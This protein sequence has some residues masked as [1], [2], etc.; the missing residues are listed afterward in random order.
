MNG[1]PA[2]LLSAF[3]NGSPLPSVS[4]LSSWSDN[5]WRFPKCIPSVPAPVLSWS[6]SMSDGTVFSDEKWSSLLYQFRAV[7]WCLLNRHPHL[8][9]LKP[10]NVSIFSVAIRPLARWMG[11]RSITSLSELEPDFCQRYLE[12]RI[13]A[14]RTQASELK[15]TSLYREAHFLEWI[16][17]VR[18]TLQDFG[19]APM[20]SPPFRHQRAAKVVGQIV[21]PPQRKLEPVPESITI[22]LL[23]RSSALLEVPADDAVK[24]ASLLASAHSEISALRIS[25]A[26]KFRKYCERISGF[27]FSPLQK[28]DKPWRAPVPPGKDAVD[29]AYRLIFLVR[30]AALVFFQASTG[31]RSSEFGALTCDSSAVGTL[32]NC[33]SVVRSRS[34]LNELFVL[35][36]TTVKLERHERK[37]EWVIGLRPIGSSYIPPP[38]RALIVLKDLLKPWRDAAGTDMLIV[39]PQWTIGFHFSTISNTTSALHLA[40]RLRRFAA[41]SL[42]PADPQHSTRDPDSRI[43]I[44]RGFK[45]LRPHRWRTTWALFAYRVDARLLT[46]I[47]IHFKHISL[48][49]T[50]RGYIGNDLEQLQILDDV[51]RDWT[52]RYFYECATG[53]RIPHGPLADLVKDHRLW[54]ARRKRRASARSLLTAI[55]RGVDEH[56]LRIWSLEEGKCLVSLWPKESRCHELAQS[57]HWSRS[58]PNYSSR[59]AGV[60]AS[61]K[62]FFPDAENKRFWIER[63]EQNKRAFEVGLK[64]DGMAGVHVFESRYLQAAAVLRRIGFGKKGAT[65]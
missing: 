40:C 3:A 30:D 6:F 56:K 23:N 64:R 5:A 31:L 50:E 11:D 28:S 54:L 48:A 13:D 55:R 60:C 7:V 53:R 61:C 49:M 9:A 4:S 63:Y 33:V 44:E 57:S 58:K 18:D 20:P 36:G 25:S 15:Y 42:S 34:G 19:V 22:E 32:P 38:V 16:Y 24:M 2:R 10:S 29:H 26:D 27:H 1:E 12:H 62:C 47:S 17:L 52:V 21:P 8:N 59:S 45:T 37:V 14:R 43:I 41:E 51:N 65:K 46:A 35:K 39:S